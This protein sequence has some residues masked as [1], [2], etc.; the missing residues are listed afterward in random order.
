[1]KFQGAT[2]IQLSARGFQQAVSLGKRLAAL[3]PD[4]FYASDLAR[5]YET[6]KII[7]SHHYMP[8]K[9]VP[10]L[11]ELNFGEWEGLTSKE[12]EKLYTDEVK[13]WWEN[14]FLI[15][16]PG[17]ETYSELIERSVNAVKEIIERHTDGHI[18]VISHGGPIRSVVGSVLGMDL[19]KYWR[20]GLHNAS[21]SIL[22][23]SGGWENGILSLF[24]DC[25]H[26]A[27]SIA[28]IC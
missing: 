12:I 4:A 24:N 10:G 23:F 8:V 11:R 14:P 27:D 19:S 21:L 20:L 2:D 22:D 17:G 15:R 18:V 28:G 5:A 7:S 16:I 9:K 6:A 1:M 13:K 26:L 3:K 25:S